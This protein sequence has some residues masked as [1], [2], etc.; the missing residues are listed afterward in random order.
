[1]SRRAGQEPFI[2]NVQ[3]KRIRTLVLYGCLSM[4]SLYHDACLLAKRQLFT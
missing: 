2:L 4:L 1:M 3:G